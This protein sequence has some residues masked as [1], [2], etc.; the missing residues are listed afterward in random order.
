MGS[1]RRDTRESAGVHAQ[2]FYRRS[3][4]EV[5][6]LGAL[7]RSPVYVGFSEALDGAP[8]IRGFQARLSSLDAVSGPI[9]AAAEQGPLPSL[10]ILPVPSA[11]CRGPLR[12][13]VDIS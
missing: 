2:G 12:L 8:T 4:R 1:R 10:R 6:R 9:F 13:C 3:S 11:R 5:R 7:A